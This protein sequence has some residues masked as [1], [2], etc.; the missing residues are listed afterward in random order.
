MTRWLKL[1]RTTADPAGTRSGVHCLVTT[2]SRPSGT[3]PSLA[4][5]QPTVS[6]L[7]ECTGGLHAS[8]FEAWQLCMA[9]PVGQLEAEE[10]YGVKG[11][12][13]EHDAKDRR[14]Q[15]LWAFTMGSPFLYAF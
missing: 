11:G 13:G 14:Y 9:A 12:K 4:S 15:K 2:A 6:R 5:F 7:R 10:E 8:E 1:F 3:T